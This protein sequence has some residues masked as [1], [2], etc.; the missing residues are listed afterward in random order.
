M[1]RSLKFFLILICIFS[2]QMV[3]AAE[4]PVVLDVRDLISAIDSQTT[5]SEKVRAVRS[6]LVSQ[7]TDWEQAENC[8]LANSPWSRRKA[9][10]PWSQRALFLNIEN[11]PQSENGSRVLKIYRDFKAKPKSEQT[12]EAWTEMKASMDNIPLDPIPDCN[13]LRKPIDFSLLTQDHM[14]ILILARI[15]L[16]RNIY[17]AYLKS[18]LTARGRSEVYQRLIFCQREFKERLGASLY[19]FTSLT[20]ALNPSIQ[21]RAFNFLQEAALLTLLIDRNT[22]HVCLKDHMDLFLYNLEAFDAGSVFSPLHDMQ[23]A[24]SLQMRFACPFY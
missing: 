21:N 17:D 13:V 20:Q 5:E 15:D 6:F 1:F 7:N 23:D 16:G 19:C 8:R 12:F 22:K 9:Q 11:N 4:Q 10:E 2:L 3:S 18:F 24:R 14:R